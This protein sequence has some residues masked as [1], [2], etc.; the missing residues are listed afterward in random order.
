MK[1]S[2]QVGDL[3]LQ[4]SFPFDTKKGDRS[5]F[6]MQPSVGTPSEISVSWSGDTDGQVEIN[7]PAGRK[8]AR[9]AKQD[10]R[11]T[12]T[13][14]FLKR[15]FPIISWLP[16]YTVQSA[17]QDWMAG[18]TVALTAIPQ[19]I[20]YGAVAGVPVEVSISITVLTSNL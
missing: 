7:A 4:L 12:C 6:R 10:I 19:G 8:W 11:N 2:G 17:F 5:S 14:Q 1:Q 18:L 13:T 16:K 3:S 20:A 9:K 15:R